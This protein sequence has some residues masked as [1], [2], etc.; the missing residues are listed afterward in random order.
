MA[1][2]V[3][4]VD[5]RWWRFDRYKLEDGFIKPHPEAV[6]TSY[7]PWAAYWK[8]R[9]K[10]EKGGRSPYVSLVSLVED[11]GGIHLLIDEFSAK[12]ESLQRKLDERGTERL[13]EWCA[14]HGLLGL[15][16]D[17]IRLARFAPRWSK[18]DDYLHDCLTVSP[19]LVMSGDYM[20]S[21]KVFDPRNSAFDWVRLERVGSVDPAQ[22]KGFAAGTHLA[23]EALL[24]KNMPFVLLARRHDEAYSVAE[25]W[26]RYFPDLPADDQ[27]DYPLPGRGEEERF[28]R[29][30]CEPLSDFILAAI[31]IGAIMA[32]CD[33]QRLNVRGQY[34]PE[35]GENF[36]QE[37]GLDAL[38]DLVAS[39][40]PVLDLSADGKFG[41][42]WSAPSLKANLGMMLVTDLAA[43]AR[44]RRCQACR[45]IFFSTAYQAKFC[46]STHRHRKL[47]Q[48]QR[49]RE[50]ASHVGTKNW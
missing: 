4:M 9:Q 16:F 2:P 20:V 37:Q 3:A 22:A 48:G 49:A 26:G 38:N 11:L 29:A 10:G 19:P 6:L 27:Y 15:L 41:L 7:N 13:L 36:W 35:F 31:G 34:T 46:C 21:S 18:T 25:A 12:G 40:R 30:Y 44:A 32:R 8:S 42:N 50:K 23:P 43:G 47:K 39:A 45:A 5:G 1:L 28:W 33:E 24:D 14:T 17:D